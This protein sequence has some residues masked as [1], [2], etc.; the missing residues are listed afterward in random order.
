MKRTSEDSYGQF[1][2]TL[3]DVQNYYLESKY[4]ADF[5]PHYDDVLLEQFRI[6]LLSEI[7]VFVD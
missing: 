7:S 6:I 2:Q 3:R 1:L 4:F 5:Q